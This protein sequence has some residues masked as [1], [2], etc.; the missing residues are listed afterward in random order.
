MGKKKK[1]RATQP[2]GAAQGD[3]GG[4]ETSTRRRTRRAHKQSAGGA[5][6]LPVLPYVRPLETTSAGW[7]RPVSGGDDN[8]VIRSI[9][10]TLNRLVQANFED[11][12]FELKS[13]GISTQPLLEELIRQV[14]DKA[15][16]EAKWASM[17]AR[18]CLRLSTEIA[19]PPLFDVD[20]KPLT[21]RRLLLNLCLR[22]FEGNQWKANKKIPREGLDE[23]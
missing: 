6:Q 5:A 19:T 3:S 23:A 12:L 9:T 4:G 15:V 10:V 7:R 13:L 21:F 8:M 22:E 16:N 17:Y 11:L 1:R 18:L 14:F 20:G 2:G